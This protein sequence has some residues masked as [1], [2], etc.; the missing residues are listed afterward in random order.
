VCG[1]KGIIVNKIV[2]VILQLILVAVFA[3]IA[4]VMQ[5]MGSDGSLSNGQLGI[6]AL[7][8]PLCWEIFRFF[9][10][11]WCYF[12][13]IVLAVGSLGGYL[14]ANMDN[15]LSLVLN[16]QALSGYAMILFAVFLFCGTAMVC[17]SKKLGL[18]FIPQWRMPL[19][20]WL[21]LALLVDFALELLFFEKNLGLVLLQ[22]KVSALLIGLG[23]GLVA[24]ITSLI[25]CK[26]T[27]VGLERICF[28]G[29]SPSVEEVDVPEEAP[30]EVAPPPAPA[31]APTRPGG[32]PAMPGIRA[33]RAPVPSAPKVGG[34][35]P[36]TS[37]LDAKLEALCSAG[38]SK[39][40]RGEAAGK[41]SAE[42][43]SPEESKSAEKEVPATTET[44]K[45][46]SS[47][48]FG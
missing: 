21:I 12:A 35:A 8:I 1:V 45:I 24:K 28:I 25:A 30:A 13:A 40:K 2:N 43:S 34:G 5:G 17:F 14:I 47:V 41:K 23:I 7:C 42:S 20:G 48:D 26:I 4:F 37:V 31:P 15:E 18:F 44:G 36:K 9:N 46:V 22:V 33:P 11:V 6:F 29:Y 39:K 38:S 27:G 16:E 3:G 19:A 10:S 32:R